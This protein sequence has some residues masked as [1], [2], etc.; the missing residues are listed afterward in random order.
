MCCPDLTVLWSVWRV[1]NQLIYVVEM[2]CLA[3]AL[4]T[5]GTKGREVNHWGNIPQMQVGFESTTWTFAAPHST[6]FTIGVPQLIYV[7]LYTNSKENLCYSS[8]TLTLTE[9]HIV[10]CSN[11]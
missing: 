3:S 2:I 10:Y 11:N 1:H 8:H 6:L 5:P 9:V 7:T 4:V